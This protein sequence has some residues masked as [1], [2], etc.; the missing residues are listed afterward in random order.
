[1]AENGEEKWMRG[2]RLSMPGAVTMATEDVLEIRMQKGP[3][4][5]WVCGGNAS[6]WALGIPVYEGLVLPN[7]WSKEWG[8]VPACP[9][10]F[11]AQERLAEPM[12]KSEFRKL[13]N[14]VY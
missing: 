2:Q 13:V 10:C 5:C 1:M 12:E 6:G 8:G 11:I 7:N 14:Q 4:D 3:A 9:P